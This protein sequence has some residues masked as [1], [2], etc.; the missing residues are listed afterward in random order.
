MKKK[1]VFRKPETRITEIAG[2]EESLYRILSRPAS[3]SVSLAM[4]VGQR[5]CISRRVCCFLHFSWNCS[6]VAPWPAGLPCPNQLSCPDPELSLQS[7]LDIPVSLVVPAWNDLC[8]FEILRHRIQVG[9]IGSHLRVCSPQMNLMDTMI[10]N[11]N[12]SQRVQTVWF[13]LCET[14]KHAKLIHGD[15]S[16]NYYYQEGVGTGKEHEGVVQ[17]LEMF[18]ILTWSVSLCKN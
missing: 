12:Q 3:Y 6:W 18:Q 2:G 17:V 13:H 9:I 16:Q 1:A 7:F 14:Q 11:Q 8:H 15:R 5:E 4:S 10:S